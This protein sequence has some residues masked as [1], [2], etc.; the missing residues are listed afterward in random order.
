MWLLASGPLPP[1]PSEILGSHQMTDLLKALDDRAEVVVYDSPPLLPV[2]D[3][4]VLAR[5]TDGALL[6]VRHGSTRR[7]QVTRALEAL[8]NVDA[9]LLGTVLNRAPSRGPDADSYGYGP[10][11]YSTRTDK[12]HMDSNAHASPTITPGKRDKARRRDVRR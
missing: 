6:V 7:E 10:G 1:N 8:K 4:A 12:T 9:T 2:T 3:A 11:Y 5:V